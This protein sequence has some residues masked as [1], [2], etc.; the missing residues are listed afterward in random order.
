MFG[1]VRVNAD[2]CL[3]F[4]PLSAQ[5]DTPNPFTGFF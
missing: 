5:D 2:H 4:L 1:I 3:V